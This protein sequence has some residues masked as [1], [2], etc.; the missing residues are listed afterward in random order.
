VEL[1]GKERRRK[2]TN[3]F[4]VAATKEFVVLSTVAVVAV[5]VRSLDDFKL[6]VL[7]LLPI[8]LFLLFVLFVVLLGLHRLVTLLGLLLFLLSA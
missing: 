4:V 8:V 5:D 3:L 7:L 2:K 6:T 1:E